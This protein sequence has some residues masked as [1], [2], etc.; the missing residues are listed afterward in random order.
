MIDDEI[1]RINRQLTDGDALAARHTESISNWTLQFVDLEKLA[2]R[3]LEM[4]A[5]LQGAVAALDGLP[6]LPEGFGA[7]KEFLK[8]LELAQRDLNEKQQRLPGLRQAFGELAG[9]LGDERSEDVAEKAAAAERVF[10]RARAQGRAYVRIQQELDHLAGAAGVDPLADFSERVAG[11]FSR[12]AGGAAEIRF[13]GQ[14]P[15]TVVRGA[16]SLPPDRL[17][18]GGGGA[19]A[20]AVRLAMAE[21]YLKGRGGFL[22]LDDPLVHFDKDRMA[23]AA[24][25][26]H[27][28]SADTQVLFFT[29][30]DHHAE[31]LEGGGADVV[32]PVDR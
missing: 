32:L 14:L 26:L 20:L 18:H 12:I 1:G 21:A 3:W 30:H 28:F 8:R 13:D 9:E 6:R 7:V 25:V 17:S 23:V 19:L 27:A 22:I 10:N 24:A 2:E 16:V 5:T 29:C 31:Q 15:A 4:K 11:L